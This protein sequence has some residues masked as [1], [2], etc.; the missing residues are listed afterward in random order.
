MST[1]TALNPEIRAALDA[2]EALQKKYS[3]FGTTDTEPGWVFHNVIRQAVNRK[4]F[5]VS[6]DSGWEIFTSVRGH[7]KVSRELTEAAQ[8]V[9]DAVL[10]ANADD[11]KA[12]EGYAWRV[13]F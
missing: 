2:F 6:P 9:Y 10:K 13:S 7:E 11:V 1:T 4:P 8:K 3:E 5:R 12:L